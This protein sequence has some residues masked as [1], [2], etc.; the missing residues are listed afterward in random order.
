[1]RHFALGVVVGELLLAFCV[2]LRGTDEARGADAASAARHAPADVASKG[3]VGRVTQ[4]E[5]DSTNSIGMRMV[6][7]PAGEFVMG[8]KE[9]AEELAKAFGHGDGDPVFFQTGRPPHRVR[10]TKP[11]YFGVYPVTRGQ[12]RRFVNDTGYKTEADLAVPGGDFGIRGGDALFPDGTVA[13]SPKYTWRNPGFPQTDEHPVVN[14]T[15]DDAVAFCRWLNRKEGK[16]YRLPTEAEWEYACRAGTQ[17]RYY[18]GDDPEKLAQVGNVADGTLKE[19]WPSWTQRLGRLWVP[20][21]EP[22]TAKDGYV[23]TSPVGS[24]KPNAWGLHDM[25]GNVWQWCADW[26]DENYYGVSSRDDPAG[27]KSGDCRV[28]RGGSFYCTPALAMSSYRS[29]APACVRAVDGGFRVLR[30]V[31]E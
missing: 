30:T 9:S 16:T 28:L 27:P 8:F 5:R 19:W 7:I 2:G 13:F 6:L 26:S 17:T 25:H 24:F 11:F 22:I 4:A 21:D 3:H 12:F 18:S 29:K 20:G 23:F 1:M 15:W 31:G 14:V 10:I